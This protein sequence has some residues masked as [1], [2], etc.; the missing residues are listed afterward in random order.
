MADD[1]MDLCGAIWNHEM[2]MRRLL[3]LLRQS[4][5]SCSDSQCFQPST[6]TETDSGFM[7]MMCWMALAFVLYLL[8]P[9]SIRSKE[10]DLKPRDNGNVS[11]IL[12]V[13]INFLHYYQSVSWQLPLCQL[14]G[15]D[16]LR[17]CCNLLS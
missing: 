11:N 6:S 2:A 10:N 13:F 1:G 17:L 4:Q 8:R 14:D 9:S 5:Q 3:S 15:I 12:F 16:I 7:L